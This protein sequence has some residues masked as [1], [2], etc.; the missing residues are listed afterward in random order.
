[1]IHSTHLL[2]IN[3]NS[4]STQWVDWSVNDDAVQITQRPDTGKLVR[5]WT[6]CGT[7]SWFSQRCQ[8]C[9]TDGPL[10]RPRSSHAGTTLSRV[11]AQHILVFHSCPI[12]PDIPWISPQLVIPVPVGDGSSVLKL[13]EGFWRYSSIRGF[14]RQLKIQLWFKDAIIRKL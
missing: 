13:S 12:T 5:E 9:H 7:K 8:R 4:L 2:H 10:I 14:G 1:M 6:L 11:K 3:F